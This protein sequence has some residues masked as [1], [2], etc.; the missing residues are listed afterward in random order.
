TL[1]NKGFESIEI[2]NLFGLRHDQIEIVI[3]PQSI[4]HSGVEFSDGSVLA[5]MSPPDMRLPIQYAMTYP[6]RAQPVIKPLDLTAV[7]E[8][9]FRRPDFRRFPC[10]ALAQEAARRGGSLPAVLNAADEVAVDSFVAGQIRFTD[11]PKVIERTM[12]DHKPIPGLPSFSEIVEVDQWA[13]RR[14]QEVCGKR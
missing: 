10:L 12:R 5:Q 1:M 14:A 8:L 4:I 13:R 9:T 6:T 11:I 2:M 3:H 7:G